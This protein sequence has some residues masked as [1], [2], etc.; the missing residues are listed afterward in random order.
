MVT[1]FF[2]LRGVGLRGSAARYCSCSK[3]GLEGEGRRAGDVFD[4]RREEDARGARVAFVV[5]V[6]VGK[7]VKTGDLVG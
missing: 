3:D 4:R 6:V 1:V 7:R 5:V 2:S